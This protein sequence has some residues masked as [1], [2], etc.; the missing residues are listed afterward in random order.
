MAEFV[1]SAFAD[2]AAAGLEEQIS[3]LTGE[4]ITRIELRNIDGKSCADLTPAEA[5]QIRSRL[6]DHGICVSSLGSPYGKVPVN[7]PFEAH[8]DLFR[9]GLDLCSRLGCNRIRMFSFYM[10]EGENPGDWKNCVFDRLEK[11]LLFAEEAGILLVHENEKGIYGDTE[12]RCLELM[13]RFSPRMGFVFDPANFI[14]CGVRTL[15]AFDQ[16]ESYITY[17]HIKDALLADGAVVAAGH[18]DGCVPEILSRLNRDRNGEVVLTVEPHL[19]VFPGLRELQSEE[20]VHHEAYPDSMTAF[21]AAC[22]AL[23]QILL[24]IREAEKQ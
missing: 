7:A 13:K 10:P 9:R 21:H 14:Q 19:K 15:N 1:L 22:T 3:A 16:L 20:L 6:G 11:M 2:E 12:D 18:G 24:R 23:K 4:G 17:M 8:L 5:D